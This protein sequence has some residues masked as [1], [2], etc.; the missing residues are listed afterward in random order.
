MGFQVIPAVDVSAG[1]LVRLGPSGPV[2][3]DA[4]GGDPVAAALAFA[5]AGAAWIHVVDVDAALVGRARDGEVV[6]RIAGL[7]VPVQA[8]GGI[9]SQGD[10][11]DA[12]AAGA[13]RVVL[14]SQ[15]LADRDLVERLVGEQGDRLVVGL[16]VRGGELRPRAARSAVLPLDET[17]AWL[18]RLPIARLLHTGVARVGGLGGADPARVREVGSI[19]GCPTIAAGGIRGLEDLRALAASGPP[20]EGAVVGRALYEGLDLAEA[21]AAVR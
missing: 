13:T 4:F 20:I 9:G 3:V 15:A 5:E 2:P 1:T 19:V 7:G 11:N 14:G 10:V 17:L 6:G 12:L 8:S 18:S 21:L 16:E